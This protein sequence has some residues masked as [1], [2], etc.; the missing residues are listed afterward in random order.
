MS[1]R[2]FNVGDRVRITKYEVDEW[3]GEVGIVIYDDGGDLC[4]YRVRI[5]GEPDGWFDEN[6]LTPAFPTK[7][8][9]GVVSSEGGYSFFE[10]L[11]GH[12]Y[13]H[14][15]LD[16]HIGDTVRVTIEVIKKAGDR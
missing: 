9:E 6:E 1:E 13:M 16:E 10:R 8:I 7:V 11:V 15:L 5:D 14:A 12:T 2:L 4:P 3:V